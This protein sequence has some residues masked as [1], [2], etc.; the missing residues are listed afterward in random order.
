MSKPRRKARATQRPLRLER[1]LAV[2]FA[3]LGVLATALLTLHWLL[4]LE[5]TLRANAV[6]HSRL[7]AQAQAQG[8]EQRLDILDPAR[9]DAE[10]ENALAGL[11]LV[12]DPSL[13]R[14]FIRGITLELDYQLV[15]ALP[16]SLDLSLGE[17]QCADCLVSPVPLYRPSDR[18]LIGIATFYGSPQA[19]QTLIE[20]F[21]AKLILIG[22]FLLGLIALAWAGTGRLLERLNQ[23]ESNLRSLFEAA[24]FPMVLQDNAAPGLRQANQAAVDYLA[25]RR[26]ANGLLSSPTWDALYEFGLPNPGENHRERL[27][28]S[29]DGGE[30]WALVSVIP[31]QI[32][33]GAS[34][35]VSLV[36]V[37]QLKAY[38]KELHLA[39]IT[40][41]LTGLYN[42]RHLFHRLA[43]EIE[44]VAT[45][46]APFSVFLFDLDHFKRVNDSFGHGMGDE[47]L[48]RVAEVLRACIRPQD[49]AG[50]YGGE[51]FLVIMPATR[52]TEA[53]ERAEQIRLAVKSLSWSEPDL[54]MTLSGGVCE[55]RGGNIDTLLECA[56]QR[57]Y[58][59]KA[60]GRDRVVGEDTTGSAAT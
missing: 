40:D 19:L 7:L 60:A 51:E 6:S 57:L 26:D 22:G 11:L 35:L 1:S 25:L 41:G 12:K 50:R 28:G 9:R 39:S 20:D 17:A 42:R 34:H 5:P 24:P 18:Q 52:T 53:R 47:V 59:A 21:R 31:L 32:A 33:G 30:R 54:G 38:Q 16:G 36:D 48:I 13:G 45:G 37:S 58:A 8:I 49:Q 23:S 2:I 46:V 14:P 55:Y 29:Q 4:V 27:V 44:R 10:I 3:L 15:D 56:D 43:Q